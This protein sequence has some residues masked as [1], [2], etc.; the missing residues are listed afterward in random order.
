MIKKSSI[1]R[2]LY[3]NKAIMEL[4]TE[5][6]SDEGRVLDE[7]RLDYTKDNRF[8]IILST[9]VGV[10]ADLQSGKTLSGEGHENENG[11]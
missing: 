11:G 8:D 10:E 4:H 2:I 6:S 9:F 5:K 7:L 3:L 1:D